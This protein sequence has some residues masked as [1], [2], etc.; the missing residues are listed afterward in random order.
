MRMILVL[1]FLLAQDHNMQADGPIG[2]L[3][4]N[5]PEADK[6]CSGDGAIYR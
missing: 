2:A 5:R 4:L 1:I 3:E 6:F